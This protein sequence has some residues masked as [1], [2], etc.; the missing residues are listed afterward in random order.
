MAGD[1]GEEEGCCGSAEGGEGAGGERGV[2]MVGRW[3]G[4]GQGEGCVSV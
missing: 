1:G 3:L 4:G 2:F